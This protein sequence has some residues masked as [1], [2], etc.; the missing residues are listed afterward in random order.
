VVDALCEAFAADAVSM[1]EFE[2]RVEV[3]HRA[4]TEAELRELLADL[5]TSA[6]LPAT[7]NAA[8][9]MVPMERVKDY[10]VVAGVLGGGIRRGSWTA[11]RTNWAVA[12]MGGCELDFREAALPP[13]VTEVKVFAMWGGVEIVVPPDIQ[14]E[15]SGLGIMGGFEHL[16]TTPSSASPDAPIIHVTGVAIMGGV[17]VSVRHPGE[18]GRDAKRR[19]RDERRT[20]K[21]LLREK[22]D[23]S[24]P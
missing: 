20:R 14:V 21:R 19:L 5:S 24:G 8:H 1:E 3:A 2:R 4:E 7:S 16:E 13:G 10:A 11:A 12:V 22:P 9:S 15:C 6:N 18:S 17:E 23:D